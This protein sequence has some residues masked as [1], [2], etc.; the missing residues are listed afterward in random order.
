MD[1]KLKISIGFSTP[2]EFHIFPWLIKLIEGTKFSHAYVKIYSDS[3][4]RYFYYQ[5]SGLRV[6]FMNREMFE[7]TNRIVK[8]FDINLT[9]DTYRKVL[10][11]AIDKAGVEYTLIQVMGLLWIRF[12]SR[13]GCKVFNP[14]NK[15]DN[16]EFC[17]KIVAQLMK[18][19]L[20]VNVKEK[21]NSVGLQEA[22]RYVEMIERSNSVV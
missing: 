5:A 18:E 10:Q 8:E 13:I 20:G 15:Y 4:E 19:C 9:W 21:Y 2:K 1:R 11:F 14:V 22:Y 6:N 12:C 17:T 16:E 3:I 7:E